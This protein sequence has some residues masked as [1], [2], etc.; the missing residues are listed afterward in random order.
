MD[1]TFIG[2]VSAELSRRLE[3]YRDLI[4]SNAIT[5]DQANAAYLALQT[6]LWLAGGC[7]KPAITS[8]REEAREEIRRWRR[9]INR[10]AT[11]ESM[12]TD[13]RVV[14]LLDEFLENTRPVSADPVQTRL[15]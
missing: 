13:S 5:R 8:T 2:L 1:N 15:L 10:N 6:A 14:R 11:V 7:E 12:Y 3:T 4:D 9:E